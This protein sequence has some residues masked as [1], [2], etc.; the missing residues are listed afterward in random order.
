MASK[1]RAILL[2]VVLLGAGLAGCAE[3]DD[4]GTDDTT[5]DEDTG[6]RD[7][8]DRDTGERDTGERD[9]GDQNQTDRN[10]TGTQDAQMQ[11]Y[12]E[13]FEGTIDG[14]NHEENFTFPVNDS[15][16]NLT[17]EANLQ[18]DAVDDFEATVWDAEMEEVCT[19]SDSGTDVGTGMG[20]DESRCEEATQNMGNYTLQVWG[21]S[22]TEDADYTLNVTVEYGDQQTTTDDTGNGGDDRQ[23]DPRQTDERRTGDADG[24]DDGIYN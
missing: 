5:D 2:A 23:T 6:D 19:V 16:A 24:S 8:G 21:N 4:T 11:D 20:D 1:T 10:D 22:T 13:T 3:T 15:Q 14:E 12:N 9:I 7:T 18:G 17:V